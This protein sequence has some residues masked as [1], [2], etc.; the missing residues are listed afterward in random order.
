MNQLLLLVD[1]IREVK[2]STL[3]QVAIQGGVYARFFHQGP[4][5][6]HTINKILYSWFPQSGYKIDT[7]RP[8]IMMPEGAF[9]KDVYDRFL[10]RE[11]DKKIY[12]Y[13]S[14]ELTA[15]QISHFCLR[16]KAF[17]FGSNIDQSLGLHGLQPIL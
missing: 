5:S 10:G 12:V 14:L 16:Q 6:E 9:L 1:D 8:M 7:K 17:S 2:N 4:L 3:K 11:P 13:Q 15:E